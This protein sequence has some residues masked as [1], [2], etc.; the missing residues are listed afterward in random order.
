MA[1]T[2]EVIEQLKEKYQ[3]AINLMNALQVQGLSFNLDGTKLVI[4]G[5]A[6]TLAAKNRVWD[7]IKRIDPNYP[8]LVCDL[9]VS[10]STQQPRKATVQEVAMSAGA[11]AGGGQNQRHYTVQPGDT[12]SKISREFYGDANQYTKIVDA[13]RSVLP[14]A[15]AI[16]PGQKLVIPE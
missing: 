12:L 11:S 14:H 13:N 4:R 10:A 1:Q 3:S 16:R 6:P 7:Q 2:N 15:D 8:D 5:V 9:S